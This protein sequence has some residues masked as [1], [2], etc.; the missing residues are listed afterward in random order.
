MHLFMCVG[1][2]TCIYEH[3]DVYMDGCLYR[4]SDASVYA[5]INWLIFHACISV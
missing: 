1:I 2:Y 5:C 3:K 4:K